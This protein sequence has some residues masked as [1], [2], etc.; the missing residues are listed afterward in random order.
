MYISMHRYKKRHMYCV[1]CDVRERPNATVSLVQSSTL[2]LIV[3][4]LYTKCV[5]SVILITCLL[6]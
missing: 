4:S 6:V 2:A 3:C 5:S 1:L